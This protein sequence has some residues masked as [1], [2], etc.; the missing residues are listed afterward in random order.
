M[1]EKNTCLAYNVAGN[2]LK[3]I[4]TRYSIKCTQGFILY[5]PILKSSIYVFVLRNLSMIYIEDY[6]YLRMHS[7]NKIRI[8]RS[9]IYTYEI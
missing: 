5:L 8:H 6:L 3:I 7:P 1:V 2:G 4:K 9:F